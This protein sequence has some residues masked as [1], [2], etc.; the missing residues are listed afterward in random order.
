MGLPHKWKI[1]W[2]P[3]VEKELSKLP[4]KDKL[5]VF[6][7]LQQLCEADDPQNCPGVKKLKAAHDRQHRARQGNYRIIFEVIPGVIVEATYSY[8][9]R[10]FVSSICPRKDSYRGCD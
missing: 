4:R 2:D 7:R 1:D 8:K 10:L 6:G 9:G 5:A 3:R